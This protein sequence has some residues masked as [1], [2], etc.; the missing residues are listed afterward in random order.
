MI[1]ANRDLTKLDPAVADA[2]ELL[3]TQSKN[4]GLHVIIT[5]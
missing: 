5:E 2:A 4:V 1:P 3:V